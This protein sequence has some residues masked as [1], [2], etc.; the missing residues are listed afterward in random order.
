MKETIRK[1]LMEYAKTETIDPKS[2]LTTD[3]DLSSLEIAEMVCSIE[4]ELDI[5]IPEKVLVS[6]KTVG[7]IY[8][9]VDAL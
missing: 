7:D 3:L 5:E 2:N 8:D 9:Y 6:I 4:D 1:I